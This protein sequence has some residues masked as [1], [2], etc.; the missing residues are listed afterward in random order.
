[1][2]KARKLR[3]GFRKTVY[4]V[5]GVLLFL[6]SACVK[7][8]FSINKLDTSFDLKP[9][10]ATPIGY[11]DFKMDNIIEPTDNAKIIL[12]E[13]RVVTLSYSGEVSI[14]EA[15]YLF[16]FEPVSE[17]F[18]LPNPTNGVIDLFSGY[19]QTSFTYQLPLFLSNSGGSSELD[20][21]QFSMLGIAISNIQFPPAIGEI[22]IEI[23]GLKANGEPY[24]VTLIPGMEN[25]LADIQD[26]SLELSHNSDA[27]NLIDVDI[28]VFYPRQNKILFATRPL[29]EFDFNINFRRWNAI[30]GYLG[31]EAINFQQKSIQTD[32]DENFPDGEFYFQDPRL[33][34]KVINSYDIP[35]GLAI[36][37][38]SVTTRDLG[39]LQLS[40]SGVPLPSEY[41][42]P[43]YPDNSNGLLEAHDSLIFT[44]E[45]SNLKEI[46]SSKPEM[47][48]FRAF[49]EINPEDEKLQN[50]I[51]SNSEF[52]TRVD[53]Q[54]PF[55][56]R[57][58]LLTI[59][60]TL[61][62]D[63][64]SISIPVEELIQNIIF[65]LYY[66]NSY[67]ADID[68]KLYLADQEMV[69]FDTLLVKSSLIRGA[70]PMEKYSENPVYTTGEVEES[71]PGSQINDLR[72]TRFMI[73]VARL[74]TVDNRD[75]AKIFENQNL[76]MKLAVIFDISAN[77]EDL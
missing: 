73:G 28:R 64:S 39:V 26:Y 47:I 22:E 63:F 30:Y 38:I 67:P 9:A 57:A 33:R 15:G 77:I 55:F 14:D 69:V 10:V 11:F 59:K 3:E 17:S 46:T 23:P 48:S 70:K 54:L 31:N 6:V 74:N 43:A 65:K 8:E 27:K 29:V 20:S 18:S 68:L 24:R 16:R 45:N 37:P 12:N 76:Y 32:F 72:R 1:M 42:Y 4:L 44:G 13:E 51:Y 50:I 34:F 35:I 41:F 36:T 25:H 5:V 71:L 2:E 62:I 49:I 61:A 66:E 53:L 21:I 60:D 19:Y 52:Y 40:G 58:E 7:E 56:G 75:D